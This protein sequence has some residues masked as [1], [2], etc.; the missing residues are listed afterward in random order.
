MVDIIFTNRLICVS[1]KVFALESNLIMCVGL[2]HQ[3][4]EIVFIQI[5]IYFVSVYW[6]LKPWSCDGHGLVIKE[7]KAEV[8]RSRVCYA[9]WGDNFY[10]SRKKQFCF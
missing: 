7:G 6:S 5:S 1:F 3:S 9:N 2:S 4:D 10:S 8:A